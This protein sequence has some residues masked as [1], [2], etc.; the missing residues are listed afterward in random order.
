MT[1]V[2]KELR[3]NAFH[4][5]C[6]SQSWGGM[7]SHPRA[8]S[9]YNDIRYWIELAQLAE[10]G[11]LDGIFMADTLGI[12]EVYEGK[13]DAVLM[14]ASMTP[15]NDPMMTIPVMASVTEH[16][17]FGVTGNT[18]FETPFLLARRFSTLDHLTKGRVAW[19]IVTGTLD[20]AARAMGLDRLPPHDQRYTV[21]DEYMEVMY[22]LWESSWSDD[23]VIKDRERIMYADPDKIRYVQHEGPYFRCRAIHSCEPSPQR[24]PLLYSAGASS[25]GRAFAAKHA[26][27]VF[28]STNNR[29]LIRQTVSGFRDEVK[30]FGR[31]P[32][33]LLIFL[34]ATIIVAPTEAEA[35]DL[36]EEYARH[37]SPVG[38]LAKFSGWTGV[39]F[40]QYSLDDPITDIKS[41]AIQSIAEAMTA[42]ANGNIPRVRDLIAFGPGV[43][44]NEE[45]IVGSTEQVCDEIMRLVE[46]TG[47]DGLNLVR[48]VEPEALRAFVDL[49]VPELQNR[50]LFKTAYAEGTMREKLFPATQGKVLDSH[51]AAKWRFQ[52][53][54]NK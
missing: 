1:R 13:P 36:H 15:M 29:P 19:N 6:P 12:N 33:D 30:K 51:P 10:R 39:D 16:L 9:G 41:N 35:R 46:E 5:A 22:Q 28:M 2:P 24:T 42:S 21:A 14:S 17:G 44:G 32:E 37:S 8:D 43:P 4:A 27:C 45:F 47:I 25:S 38:N 31:K 54:T 53:I 26:E 49:V 7:W 11:L 50:N 20:S 3:I 34:A 18:T 48:S 52:S 40:S 23:A